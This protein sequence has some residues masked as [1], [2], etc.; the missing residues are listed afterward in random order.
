MRPVWQCTNI[1]AMSTEISD[2]IGTQLLFEN[3]RVRV[4]EQ[5]LAPGESFPRHRHS[6][7]YVQ[8]VAEGA[9][10]GAHIDETTREWVAA[11]KPERADELAGRDYVEVELEPNTVLWSTKGSVHDVVNVGD[12]R[13]RVFL[14][15]LKS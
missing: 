8:I 15:E 9:R 13:L 1:P 2:A 7:D 3:D 11:A 6:Y 10:A 12:T 5:A 14:V 4:W